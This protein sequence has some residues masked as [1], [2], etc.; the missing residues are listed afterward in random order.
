MALGKKVCRPVFIKID[1]WID[2]LNF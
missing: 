2:L 1:T